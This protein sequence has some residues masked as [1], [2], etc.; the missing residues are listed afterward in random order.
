MSQPADTLDRIREFVTLKEAAQQLG[1]V[2]FGAPQGAGLPSTGCLAC[3]L[4]RMESS[5]LI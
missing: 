3:S 5:S 4:L 1:R 2:V